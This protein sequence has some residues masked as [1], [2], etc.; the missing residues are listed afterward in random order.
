MNNLE[1]IIANHKEEAPRE[2]SLGQYLSRMRREKGIDLKNIAVTTRINYNILHGLENDHFENLPNRTYLRGFIRCLAREIGAEEEYALALL[3]RHLRHDAPS[4]TLQQAPEEDVASVPIAPINSALDKDLAKLEN[5]KKRAPQI[6]PK[7]LVAGLLALTILGGGGLLVKKILVATNQE[8]QE[9][10]EIVQRQALRALQPPPPPPPVQPPTLPAETV[11][12]PPAEAKQTQPEAEEEMKKEVAERPPAPV[13]GITAPAIRTNL[14]KR[15]IET[16]LGAIRLTKMQYPLYSLDP[17][18]PKLKDAALF[19]PHVRAAYV[20][21]IQNVFI[22]AVRGDS[23]LVYKNSQKRIRSFTLE[24]GK[25][26]SIR[27]EE[28]RLFLGNLNV[29]EIFYNNQ[30]LKA[31]TVNGVRSLIFPHQ[32]AQ[33]SEIPFF[34]YDSERGKYLTIQEAIVELNHPRRPSKKQNPDAQTQEGG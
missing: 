12:P 34:L 8:V 33:G 18:H 4:H 7:Y 1:K 15:T 14:P 28:I 32:L 23:W 5:L 13:D 16:S 25:T 21:G 20:P 17:D 9:A 22:H 10:R 30:Y 11:N 19:P 27:G 2:E 3:D 31:Q 6:P 26:L 24:Q 29:L